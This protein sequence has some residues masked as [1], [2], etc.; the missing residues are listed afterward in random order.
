MQLAYQHPELAERMVLVCS[1][2]LGREV[3]WM[4]RA[5]SLPGAEYVAPVIFP[6]FV[7]DLGDRVAGV[8][9]RFGIRSPRL[10]EIWDAYATLTDPEHRAAFLRTVHAVIEPGGQAVSATD[11]LYLAAAMPTLIVWGD[12]DPIIPV[13]HGIAAHDAMPGSRLEIFEGVG[14]FP[15][16]EEP[17]RFTSV[18]LDFLATTEPA[19][20]PRAAFEL[21]RRSAATA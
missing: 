16:A 3:T 10:A 20:D 19:S 7:R 15:H 5:L 1:G 21:V 9:Q 11:R 12:A 13:R 2:G 17:A 14:H 8:A 18:L 4:I 6:R